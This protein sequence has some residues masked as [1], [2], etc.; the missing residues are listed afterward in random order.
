MEVNITLNGRNDT[1]SVVL[2]MDYYLVL[3]LFCCDIFVLVLWVLIIVLRICNFCESVLYDQVTTVVE[4]V[5][6]YLVPWCVKRM[7][8]FSLNSNFVLFQY[9]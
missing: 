9:L 4:T 5:K 3:F 7:S 2:L 8:T 6:I 1:I